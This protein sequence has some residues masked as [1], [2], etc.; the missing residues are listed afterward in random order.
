MEHTLGRSSRVALAIAG[1]LAAVGTIGV[2]GS[3]GAYLTDSKLEASG[4]RAEGRVSEKRFVFSAEGDSDY[5]VEY[6]FPLPSGEL[7]RSQRSVPKG[8]WSDLQ[9]G[10]P[11]VVVYSG[12]NPKR[13]FPL[14]A[15]VTSLGTTV[16][17]SVV[18]AL[19]AL[20]GFAFLYGLLRARRAAA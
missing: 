4:P 20:F 10:Q 16:F 9:K 1:L 14:G 3:W 2:V 15:G 8:L 5:V 17:V 6:S 7:V 18:S 11:L 13:N 12:A 19:L